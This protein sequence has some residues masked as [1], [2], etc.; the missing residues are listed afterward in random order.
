LQ[1][2]ATVKASSSFTANFA[3]GLVVSQT[4]SSLQTTQLS[5]WILVASQKLRIVGSIHLI[6]IRQAA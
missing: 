6:S 4:L 2:E 5:G 1:A 3:T